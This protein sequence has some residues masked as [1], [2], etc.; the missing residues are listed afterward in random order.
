MW[1]ISYVYGLLIACAMVVMLIPGVI[2]PRA[3][4]IFSSSLVGGYLV[5]FAVSTFVYTSLD[6]I[7]LRVVKNASINGYL[8]T[9]GAYPFQLTGTI[10]HMTVT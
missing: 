3:M 8:S 9:T 4:N 2:F 1:T 5:I 10:D 6:E 7:V